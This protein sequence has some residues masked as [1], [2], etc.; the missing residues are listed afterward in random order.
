M[1]KHTVITGAVNTAIG[2]LF[3]LFFIS[4]GLCLALYIRPFYYSEIDRI[5]VETG[6]SPELI[7]ENYDALID[8]C[9]PFFQGD[10]SFPSLPSSATGLSHFAEVKVIF[11][12]FF[13]LLLVCPVFLAGLICLEHHRKNDSWLFAAPSIVCILPLIVA[14]GCSVN[15]SK[16]F[17]I[18]HKIMFRNDDWLFSPTDDPIIL[19]LP[20]R[21]FLKCALIILIT[22]FT[23]C[24]TLW[25]IWGFR[26]K[27]KSSR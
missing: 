7:R 14:I 24:V 4:V 10:L 6:Y 21:F 26:R 18:F 2:L 12:L 17:V 22:V 15:F 19:L 13:V 11:H 25:G 8:Y 3:L 23:G 20:E 5:S 16:A 1:K 27:R 9:S